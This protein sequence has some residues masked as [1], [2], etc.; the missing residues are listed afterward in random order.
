MIPLERYSLGSGNNDK[1]LESWKHRMDDADQRRC[2]PHSCFDKSIEN[3]YSSYPPFSPYRPFS[4]YPPLSRLSRS[5]DESNPPQFPPRSR[6]RPRVFG[7][8]LLIYRVHS[9]TSFEHP[10]IPA[11]YHHVRDH[12]ASWFRKESPISMHIVPHCS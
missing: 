12:T 6:N 1:I 8:N 11:R 3:C 7:Q 5:L 4:S 2:M 10:S 9:T